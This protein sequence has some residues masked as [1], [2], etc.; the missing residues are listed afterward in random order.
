MTENAERDRAEHNK[1]ERGN[2]DPTRIK[3]N[4][5]RINH[6]YAARLATWPVADDGPI[7]MVNLMKYH[8]VAKYEDDSRPAVSGREADDKYNPASILNKIDASIVFVADVAKDHI[9]AEDW[10]RIAIVRYASRVSF[11]EMQSRKDFSDKHV[12]KAAGMQRTTLL[13]SRPL[14]ISLD[15]RNRPS[16]LELKRVVMVVRQATDR[17]A[18]YAAMPSA[19][20]LDVEGTVLSD[21]R[22]W[23]TV[24]LISVA[25]DADAD[26]LVASIS[27]LVSGESYAM[28]LHATLDGLTA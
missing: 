26:A 14:D 8:E 4:Y 12:H 28:T 13:A 24:Q 23:D 20:V 22:M 25:A 2:T 10:D 5:G 16:T 19:T 18:I 1:T 15:T 17:A 11:I 27:G 7:Y 3:H 21:G 9:G 6:D